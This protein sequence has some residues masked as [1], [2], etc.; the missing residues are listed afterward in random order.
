MFCQTE[1]ITVIIV[2]IGVAVMLYPNA[3]RFNAWN[4]FSNLFILSANLCLV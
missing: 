2:C 1:Y 4:S 3:S